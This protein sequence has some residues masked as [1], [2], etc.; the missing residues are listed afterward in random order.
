MALDAFV[1]SLVFVFTFMTV[2][3]FGLDIRVGLLDIYG[4]KETSSELFAR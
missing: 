4:I 2:E 3:E 1:S